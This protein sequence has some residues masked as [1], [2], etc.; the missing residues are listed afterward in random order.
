MGR[1]PPARLE[2][3]CRRAWNARAR[4]AEAETPGA[5]RQ[6]DWDEADPHRQAAFRRAFQMVDDDTPAAAMLDERTK[7]AVNDSIDEDQRG[8]GAAVRAR[9][10]G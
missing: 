2:Q 4:T 8:G 3:A 6:R 7:K 9:G 1:V 5:R 10:G